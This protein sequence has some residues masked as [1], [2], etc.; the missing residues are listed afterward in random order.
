M[1][2][3]LS[4]NFPESVQAPK[5]KLKFTKWN[6]TDKRPGHNLIREMKKVQ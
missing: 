5:K 1:P 6:E 2:A 3:E 4:Q